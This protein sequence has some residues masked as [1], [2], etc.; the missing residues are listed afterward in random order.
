MMGVKVMRLVIEKDG[1]V[2]REVEVRNYREAVVE[3]AK[4]LDRMTGKDRRDVIPP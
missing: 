2:I 1:R 4:S 3:F